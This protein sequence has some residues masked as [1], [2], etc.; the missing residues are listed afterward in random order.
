MANQLMARTD[1]A[2]ER[3]TWLERNAQT[4]GW[5]PYTSAHHLMIHLK[6]VAGDS[7]E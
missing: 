3:S 5:N 2:V 1:E 7:G 4:N 6:K